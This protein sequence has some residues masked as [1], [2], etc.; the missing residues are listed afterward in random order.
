MVRVHSLLRFLSVFFIFVSIVNCSSSNSDS[1][2]DGGDD[3]VVENNL[4][5]SLS[6]SSS[7]SSVNTPLK[8][9]ISSSVTVSDAYCTSFGGPAETQ[10][11]TAD[12]EGYDLGILAIYL[13]TC[14]D[15]EGTTVLCNSTDMANITRTEIYNGTQVDMTISDSEAEFSGTF[16]ELTDTV[17]ASGFQIVTAYIQQKFPE[18]GTTE[19]DKIASSLQGKSYRICQADE[20]EIDST[21]M[22][23][24]CGRSD[25]RQGDYLI[26]LDGD[27]VFG[28]IDT[29]TLSASNID[30]VSTRPETYDDF[31]DENFV[32]NN[33]CFGNVGGTV[34]QGQEQAFDCTHEYTSETFFG[35][36]N[37]FAPLMSFTEVQTIT[38]ETVATISAVFNISGTF[39]WTDGA[40]GP[41]PSNG[42]CVGAISDQCTA[43]SIDDDDSGSV[44]VYNPFFDNAFL[45]Q[46]PTMTIS[47][48]ETE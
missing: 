35:V 25:A 27:G 41:I 17:E 22:E 37:Y 14:T 3:P 28:F 2:D 6:T 11:C 21:E 44:G 34:S 19:G 18:S 47:F 5:L 29:T 7:A 43:D 8:N 45:P 46:S 48:S 40:D 26:D 38:P 4:S 42:V 33:V 32:N 16:T 23:T 12:P 13:V 24:R 30:E 9:M 36:P 1:Q 15:A 31:N 20:N 10:D 39:M